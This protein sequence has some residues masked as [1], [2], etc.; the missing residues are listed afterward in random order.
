VE[1]E[2]FT[3]LD[4]AATVLYKDLEECRREAEEHFNSRNELGTY[5]AL[6][7]FV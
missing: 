4:E 1:K 6:E 5:L 2:N 7:K 3:A